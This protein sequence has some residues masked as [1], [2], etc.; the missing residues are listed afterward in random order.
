MK[1]RK[2]II[3]QPYLNI[4]DISILLKI[5]YP[6]AKCIYEEAKAREKTEFHGRRVSIQDVMKVTGITLNTLMKQVGID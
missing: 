2:E 1:T 6:H 3:A 4:T 5:S